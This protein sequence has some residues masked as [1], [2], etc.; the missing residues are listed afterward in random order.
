MKSPLYII[1]KGKHKSK[2]CPKFFLSWRKI[3]LTFSFD[4]SCFYD[5]ETI[6]G[7]NKLFGLALPFHGEKTLMYFPK[8][9]REYLSRFVN[10]VVIGW[11]PNE[12]NT[13]FELYKYWDN[14]GVEKRELMTDG[15]NALKFFID[16]TYQL[17][18]TN[19]LDVNKIY[20]QVKG[21]EYQ[22]I[23]KKP[24]L[25]MGYFLYFYFGGKFRAPHQMFVNMSYKIW[26]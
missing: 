18:I 24:P 26:K 25:K 22:V 3:T 10:S 14:H 20:I 16:T 17:E 8:F 21:Q 2:W 4:Q 5:R 15:I 6:P 12:N 9:I 23:V 19:Y 11:K 13:Y 1:R 7:V